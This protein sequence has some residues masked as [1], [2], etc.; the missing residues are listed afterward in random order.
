VQKDVGWLDISV[1]DILLYDL[2]EPTQDLA[3]VESRFLL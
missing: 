3:E 1:D 2:L